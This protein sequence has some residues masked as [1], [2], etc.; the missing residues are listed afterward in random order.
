DHVTES[1]LNAEI[2]YFQINSRVNRIDFDLAH[3]EGIKL[4]ND[5][6]YL[7]E[8]IIF[9]N[10]CILEPQVEIE[11]TQFTRSSFSSSKRVCTNFDSLD[12]S[13]RQ[14]FIRFEEGNGYRILS[15]FKTQITTH[16]NSVF[17]WANSSV[18]QSLNPNYRIV[19]KN[20]FDFDKVIALSRIHTG[21]GK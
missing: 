6:I 2:D 19:V 3:K 7:I 14:E 16:M 10:I 20:C 5:F 15:K 18:S 21:S 13:T 1:E 12:N 8:S 11:F 17:S 9:K 4:L